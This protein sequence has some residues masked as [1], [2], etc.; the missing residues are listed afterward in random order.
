MLSRLQV[1]AFN[2]LDVLPIDVE[3]DISSGQPN[4]VIVGLVDTAI[5][6]AKERLRAALKN[7]GF[8]FPRGKTE[9]F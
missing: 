5:Q 3:I 6:E 7:T 9:V 4:F 1:C 2:G 8:R